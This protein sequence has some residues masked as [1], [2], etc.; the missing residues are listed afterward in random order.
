MLEQGRQ[1]HVAILMTARDSQDLSHPPV[2]QAVLGN[3]CNTVHLRG[4]SPERLAELLASIG[5]G[6]VLVQPGRLT[7]SLRPR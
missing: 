5:D 2:G 7:A 3:V 4:C 6:P 1:A